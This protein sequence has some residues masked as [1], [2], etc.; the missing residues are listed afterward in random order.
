MKV[1]KIHNGI[2]Y[3]LSNED[4]KAGDKVYP[5][6]RG[7]C[8]DDGEWIFHNLDYGEYCS[9]FPNEPHTILDIKNSDYKPSEVHTDMGFSPI[10]CYYK[11]IKKEHQVSDGRKMFPI[12]KWIEIE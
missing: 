9:G 7:R 5:I 4:I 3:T 1:E 2:R 6:A 10:E 12:Y 11:I 8:L